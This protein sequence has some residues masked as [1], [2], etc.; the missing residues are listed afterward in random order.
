MVEN[1]ASSAAISGE[2]STDRNT[3]LRRSMVDTDEQREDE[4]IVEIDALE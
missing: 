3:N 4:P 2:G 1:Q